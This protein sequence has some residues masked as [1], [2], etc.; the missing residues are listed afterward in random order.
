MKNKT[1]TSITSWQKEKRNS[2]N[3]NKSP[4]REK[5][6]PSSKTLAKSGLEPD[7]YVYT[8][9]SQP[10][11]R[12]SQILIFVLLLRLYNFEFVFT[13][14]KS[15]IGLASAT[16]QLDRN[17]WQRVATYKSGS[18]QTW[19]RIFFVWNHIEKAQ[20]DRTPAQLPLCWAATARFF[21]SS[22]FRFRF[23]A[24]F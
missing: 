24:T 19:R 20:M 18:K 4:Q 9:Q 5:C 8:D 1:K 10:F 12:L 16:S 13:V 3:E 21:L 17:A 15:T 2:N 6:S 22:F 7:S 14:V 11:Y 23:R